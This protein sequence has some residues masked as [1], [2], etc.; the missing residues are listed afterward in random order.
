M[1]REKS[2]AR[3]HQSTSTP[4][5]K[6]RFDIARSVKHADEFDTA[7]NREIEQ[8]VRADGEAS[9]SRTQLGSRLASPWE[10]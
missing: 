3:H 10:V 2:G 8:K 1:W 5:L 6:D 4:S 7:A 9:Q